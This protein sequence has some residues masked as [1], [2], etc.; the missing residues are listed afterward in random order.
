M[1]EEKEHKGELY[2]SF[3]NKIMPVI[4]EMD[5]EQ[6]IEEGYHKKEDT[7]FVW[8]MLRTVSAIS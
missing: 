3:S 2:G 4:L 8:Q 1:Y 6:G 5:P 7:N